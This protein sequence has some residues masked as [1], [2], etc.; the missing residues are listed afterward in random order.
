MVVDDTITPGRL[1]RF[2]IDWSDANGLFS[3][4]TLAIPLGTPTVLFTENASD[5]LGQWTISPAGTWGVVSNDP[6]HPSRY[7]N[8]SPGG[9]YGSGANAILSQINPVDLSAGVHAYA[10]FDSRWD[11]ESDTDAGLVEGSLN[12]VAWQLLQST[13]SSPGSGIFSSVQLAGQP[14]FA[15]TRWQ[16]RTEWADLSGLTGPAGAAVRV[17][18]R[19]RSNNGGN[20][21]GLSLDSLRVL[22]Y[23]PAAQPALVA[24]D[25]ARPARLELA[26]PLPNP[27]RSS[28][29]F[30]FSIPSAA[31]VRLEVID[32]QGRVVRPLL[33]ERAQPGHYVRGWDLTDGSG[34]RAAPGMYFVRL[35]TTFG[36]LTQRFVLMD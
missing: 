25:G 35:A 14:Y 21:D 11:F 13:G 33:A 26:A 22:V 4:D 16:W 8:D 7:L 10:V 15:G 2:Q 5:G 30:E 29:R 27:A 1:V 32:V 24:V 20:F 19:A 34:H 28:A 6:A 18:F 9:S 12:G 23:D 3:R 36:T 17:R 31:D